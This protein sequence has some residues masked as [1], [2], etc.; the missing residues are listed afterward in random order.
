MLIPKPLYLISKLK[1]HEKDSQ[2]GDVEEEELELMGGS[3][4]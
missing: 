1:S 3:N 2:G 4:D